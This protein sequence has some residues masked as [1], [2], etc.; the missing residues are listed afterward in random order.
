MVFYLN[1]VISRVYGSLLLSLWG[2][3]VSVLFLQDEDVCLRKKTLAMPEHSATLGNSFFEFW[4]HKKCD[5]FGFMF[6]LDYL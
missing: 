6:L 5:T 4:M 2:A 1:G 3:S